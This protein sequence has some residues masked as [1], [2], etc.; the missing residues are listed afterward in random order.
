MYVCKR[1]RVCMC[2][3]VSSLGMSNIEILHCNYHDIHLVGFK[4]AVI[5]K[6]QVYGKALYHSYV[7]KF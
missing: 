1:I 2:V 3:R 4:N 6:S 5:L 7:K